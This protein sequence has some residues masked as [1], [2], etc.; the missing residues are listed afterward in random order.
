MNLAL[1]AR[2]CVLRISQVRYSYIV[3]TMYYPLLLGTALIEVKGNLTNP[4][5]IGFTFSEGMLE[6]STAVEREPE[7]MH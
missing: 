7:G 1:T 3:T 6:A 2:C 4:D 5:V